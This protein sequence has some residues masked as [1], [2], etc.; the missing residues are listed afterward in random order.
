MGLLS[1]MP[2]NEPGFQ[3]AKL[4]ATRLQDLGLSLAGSPLE[5]IIKDFEAER[6]RAGIRRLRP[7]FYLST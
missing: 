7:R 3:E 6:Q 4:G 5:S 1:L 2:V